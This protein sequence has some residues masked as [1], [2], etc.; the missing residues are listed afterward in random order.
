MLEFS[1]FYKGISIG[2]GLIISIGAQNAFV[3]KQ[4][5]LKNQVFV[6]ALTCALI[7]TI[8]IVVGVA[9]LGRIIALNPV[10]LSVIKYGCSIFLVSYAVR[11][12]RNA[13]KS[14]I[15]HIS[16]SNEKIGCKHAM[17]TAIA[18]SLLNPYLYL[19]T[20]ILIGSIG[21]QF[22]GEAQ[23]SFASG[24]ILA[25]FIWFFTISYGGRFVLPIFQKS[26]SWK[27]LDFI[28]GIIMLGIAL[29]LIIVK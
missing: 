5:I 1:P 12:F 14:D 4:G 16:N 27:I 10:L 9:G 6:I 17:I 8:L 13:F 21:S 28:I 19:D 2:L 20:C 24:A 22:Y 15:L 7:D 25:S 23:I 26:I 11:S 18:V 29:S 3:I